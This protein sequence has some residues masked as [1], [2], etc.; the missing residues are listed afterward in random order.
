MAVI[1]VMTVKV[2]GKVPVA[3]VAIRA[4]N[5]DQYYEMIHA[6]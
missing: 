1:T 6:G 4:K 2:H 3:T 5:M